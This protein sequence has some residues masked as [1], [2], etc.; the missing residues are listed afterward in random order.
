MA[1]VSYTHLDVYK[2]QDVINAKLP[3]QALMCTMWFHCDCLAIY[4]KVDI[5]SEEHQLGN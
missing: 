4:Y 3:E 5:F 2:R 1:T